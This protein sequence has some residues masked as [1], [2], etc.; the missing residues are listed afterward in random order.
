MHWFQSL[1]A[2]F[3]ALLFAASL[4]GAED[5]EW[6]DVGSMFV[7]Q[8][9]DKR[10]PAACGDRKWSGNWKT[11]R[12]PTTSLCECIGKKKAPKAQSSKKGTYQADAG[13][14]ISEQDAKWTCPRKC[15]NNK[16]N[17]NWRYTDPPFHSATCE[18]ER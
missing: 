5:V 18:C 4:A 15:G 3:L 16:W 14:I 17:G 9:A 13:F 12:G 10:C 6:V 11:V 7:Q 1:A 2:G 8:H